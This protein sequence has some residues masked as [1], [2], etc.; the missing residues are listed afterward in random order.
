MA[1]ICHEDERI[2]SWCCN[3]LNY[4]NSLCIVFDYF[5][6]EFIGKSINHRIGKFTSCI[7]VHLREIFFWTFSRWLN[8]FSAMICEKFQE[9]WEV[10]NG[11]GR[12]DQG[13]LKTPCFFLSVR[14][15]S[16]L[17]D[18]SSCI[19]HLSNANLIRISVCMHYKNLIKVRRSQESAKRRFFCNYIV[20]SILYIGLYFRWISIR[21][22]ISRL[23]G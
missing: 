7:C 19:T 20:K 4:R 10:G 9:K 21:L 3:G 17:N 16:F 8:L 5:H 23:C 15:L 6:K 22:N 1:I 18:F 11:K 14:Y 12:E 13:S 2:R